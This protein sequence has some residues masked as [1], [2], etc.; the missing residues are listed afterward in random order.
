LPFLVPP[1]W[2]LL[3]LPLPPFMVVL[4]F[5]LARLPGSPLSR[6]LCAL[7]FVSAAPLPPLARLSALG[8]RM[9]I[10]RPC[11]WVGGGGVNAG[12][13]MKTLGGPN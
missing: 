1:L 3:P 9:M 6:H 7:A 13:R 5:D 2:L 8:G 4:F 10:L 11:C 12:T